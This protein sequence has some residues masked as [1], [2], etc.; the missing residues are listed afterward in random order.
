MIAID[1]ADDV[2]PT[3]RRSQRGCVTRLLERLLGLLR[4]VC[5]PPEQEP[6]HHPKGQA[7]RTFSGRRSSLCALREKTDDSRSEAPG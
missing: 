6:S 4:V 1:G 5:C 3:K 2:K 7:Q